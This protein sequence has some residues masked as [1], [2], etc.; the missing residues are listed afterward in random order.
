MAPY[1]LLHHIYQRLLCC[2]LQ[3]LMGQSLIWLRR[4]F[5]TCG[6]QIVAR[7]FVCPGHQPYQRTG[8]GLYQRCSFLYFDVY[9]IY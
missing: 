8:W 4:Y 2:R 5:F 1:H 9:Q 7:Q 6:V 3:Y